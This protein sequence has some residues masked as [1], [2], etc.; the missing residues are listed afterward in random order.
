MEGCYDNLNAKDWRCSED[1]WTIHQ[2]FGSNSAM[3]DIESRSAKSSTFVKN[4]AYLTITILR[5]TA[6]SIAPS[7]CFF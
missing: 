6:S 5:F 7:T 3:S 1:P 4:L 2:N